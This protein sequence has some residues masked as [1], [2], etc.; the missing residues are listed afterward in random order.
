MARRIKG[1]G[2]EYMCSHDA[3]HVS[4]TAVY[5]SLPENNNEVLGKKKQNRNH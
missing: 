1:G 5:A 2:E 3:I 4:Y